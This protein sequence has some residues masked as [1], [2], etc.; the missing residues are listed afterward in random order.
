MWDVISRLKEERKDATVILTSHSMEE[1]EALCTRVGIMVEGQL[2]C[3]GPIQH[4]KSRFGKGLIVQVKMLPPTDDMLLELSQR[5]HG[6]N[7]TIEAHEESQLDTAKLL[8]ACRGLGD[9]DLYLRFNKQD[10]SGWAVASELEQHGYVSESSL[11]EWWANEVAYQKLEA[12][13]LKKF[14]VVECLERRGE[15][16]KWRVE[17]SELTL[18]QIFEVLELQKNDLRITEYAVTQATL[19]QIFVYFASQQKNRA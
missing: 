11:M 12:F 9:A 14:S 2:K 19:E 6:K 16:S 18:G 5:L 1:C 13:F 3:L 8:D 17:G 10:V 15:H 4:L 7:S